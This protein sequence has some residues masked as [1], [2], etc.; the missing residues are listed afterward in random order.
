MPR[1]ALVLL[2]DDDL[3]YAKIRIDDASLEVAIDAPGATSTTRSPAPWS[4]A[5]PGTRRATPRS[6]GRDYVDLVLGNI[7]TE[8]EATTIRL[9]LTQLTQVGPHLRGAPT[10]AMRRSA[11]SATRS[12][13]LAQDAEAGSD[14]QFQFVKFFANI[15]S[16]TEHAAIL[17]APARRHDEA[18]RARDRHRPGLGAA[19]G[20]RAARRRRRARDR[21]RAR[22]GQHRERPAG[23]RA[24]P[25]H[26][27][28]AARASS[29]RS[30]PRSSDPT[31][32]NAMLRNMGLGF[33]H[34]NDPASLETM[35]APYFEALSR[36]WKERSYSIAQ[37][38]ILGFYPAPLASEYL[39]DATKR[40]ARREPGR[41]GAAP[42][43]RSRTSRAS[44]ARSRRRRA[45]R[46]AEQL[47]VPF[48]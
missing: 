41:P 42:P 3:A 14:A 11:A 1:P 38:I 21:G 17:S 31:I 7:A 24:G 27:R 20:P 37:Y 25:R 15:A 30:T 5:R 2:N 6:R 19:R 33:Q 18:R 34:V 46:R 12:G 28:D 43:R 47:R 39:V 4:G 8:T 36:V 26:D 10:R 40:L 9:S 35:A 45:T 16:T 23:R 13:Q 29:P 22:E 32:P 44:S 48:R